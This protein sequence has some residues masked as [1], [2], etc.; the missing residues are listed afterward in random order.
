[1]VLGERFLL[2]VC[3]L[4][5]VRAICSYLGR[6]RQL[7]AVH[8]GIDEVWWSEITDQSDTLSTWTALSPFFPSATWK[9]TAS[10]LRGTNPLH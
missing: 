9:V 3:S 4:L 5:L 6:C 7:P 10:P 1:M 2:I 8:E